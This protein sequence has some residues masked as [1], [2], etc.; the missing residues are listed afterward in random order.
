[1]AN[2]TLREDEMYI[3]KQNTTMA[4]ATGKPCP[5]CGH[6]SY[7]RGGVH[8]QC[9]ALLADQPFLAMRQRDRATKKLPRSKP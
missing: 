3:A 9:S 8:P 2:N 7:S 1:M 6:T 4:T 5:V